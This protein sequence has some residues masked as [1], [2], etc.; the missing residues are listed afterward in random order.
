[1]LDPGVGVDEILC[2]FLNLTTESRVVENTIVVLSGETRVVVAV[3]FGQGRIGAKE[4]IATGNRRIVNGRCTGGVVQNA[5]A[6]R[7][8]YGSIGQRN[9]KHLGFRYHAKIAR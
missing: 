3:K 2:Q 1:M 7:T 8:D 4:W 5:N 6:Q 9:A